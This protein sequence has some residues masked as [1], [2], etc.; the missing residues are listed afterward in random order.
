MAFFLFAAS[1][2]AG[3]GFANNGGDKCIEK[4]GFKK[5]AERM[6]DNGKAEFKVNE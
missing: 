2:I 3:I 1:L 5:C 6:I 4:D